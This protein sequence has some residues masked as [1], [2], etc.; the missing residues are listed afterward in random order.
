MHGLMLMCRNIDTIRKF[1]N[2][3]SLVADDTVTGNNT[4]K[5]SILDE[6]FDDNSKDYSHADK[7]LTFFGFTVC[8]ENGLNFMDW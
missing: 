8:E 3:P 2:E 4:E 7:F 6:I 1:V 5:W